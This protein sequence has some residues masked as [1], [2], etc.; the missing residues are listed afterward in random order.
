[1]LSQKGVVKQTSGLMRTFTF[2]H[3]WNMLSEGKQSLNSF[4]QLQGNKPKMN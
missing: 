2:Q 3:V 4:L 1:M